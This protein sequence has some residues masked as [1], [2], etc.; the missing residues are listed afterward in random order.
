EFILNQG[1]YEI[2]NEQMLAAYLKKH[3]PDGKIIFLAANPDLKIKGIGTKL[4]TEFE[5]REK[6]KEIFLF[7][8]SGCT[9]QFYE[10]RGF[11]RLKEKISKIK[12]L[13]KEIDLRCM[14]YR[15]IIQ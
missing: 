7:T 8:D 14:L 2:A 3:S 12:I 9:Y 10:R 6:G 11:E 5:K 15:K 13:D 1:V 4:L